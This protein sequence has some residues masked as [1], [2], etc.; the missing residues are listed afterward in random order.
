VHRFA[1]L[2]LDK[3]QVKIPPPPAASRLPACCCYCRP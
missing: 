1:E 3:L 2:Q